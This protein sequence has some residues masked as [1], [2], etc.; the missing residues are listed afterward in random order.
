MFLFS[1][2]FLFKQYG[3]DPVTFGYFMS[4]FALLTLMS[5]PVLGRI[6]DV[7]GSRWVLIFSNL[8]AAA[9]HLT[10]SMA[11]GVPMLLLS[12]AVS[13]L[14]DIL[15]GNIT[16]LCITRRIS[17]LGFALKNAIWFLLLGAPFVLSNGIM[18]SLLQA[19]VSRVNILYNGRNRLN[20]G[21]R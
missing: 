1:S 20:K 11:G 14:M 7:F 15:P 8:S 6:A 19:E 12:R 9:A 10:M 18:Y 16:A 2:Q 13:L 17:C 3:M 4:L 5:S 21:K